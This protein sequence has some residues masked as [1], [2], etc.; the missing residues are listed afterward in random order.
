VH[1]LALME[2]VVEEV[3]ERLADERVAVVRLAIGERAGVARDALAFCFDVCTQ[4]T[5]LENATLDI[6]TT[7]G[8]ELQLVEVEVL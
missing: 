3:I 4:G 8:A 5:A 7:P 6:V 1:E 2:C